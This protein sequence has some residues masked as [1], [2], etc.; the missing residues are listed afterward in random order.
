MDD[1]RLDVVVVGAGV[2]GLETALAL[3]AIAPEHVTVELIAP[4]HEFVYRPLTVV[5]PFGIGHSVR[6]PLERLVRAAGARLRPA[7][8]AG[9]DVA[10]KRI[11]LDDGDERAY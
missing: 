4:E 5:E 1:G 6:A 9:V 8:L 3:N 7:A 11:A 10:R 2:A